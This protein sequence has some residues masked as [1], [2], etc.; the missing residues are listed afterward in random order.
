MTPLRAEE[1][2]A[3]T[4]L[5]EQGDHLVLLH[6]APGTDRHKVPVWYKYQLPRNR[7]SLQQCLDHLEAGGLLGHIPASLG[8]AVVDVDESDPD[9]LFEWMSRYRPLGDV[10]SQRAG[11]LHLYYD[12]RAGWG[13]KNGRRL[14]RYGMRVDVRCM[15]MVA[16]WDLSAVAEI[17]AQRAMAV[18]PGRSLPRTVLGLTERPKPPEWGG[19]PPPERETR[20]PPRRPVMGGSGAYRWR[21]PAPPDELRQTA[22]GGRNT[23][24]FDAV[25]RS[26]YRLPRGSGDDDVRRRWEALWGGFAI[27]ANRMFPEPLGEREVSKTAASVSRW[28]WANPEFGR[29]GDEGRRDPAE[30][31]K[32]G[33]MSGVVRRLRVR[34][35]NAR[36]VELRRREG[37]GL[38]AIA[39]IVEVSASTVWRAV[40]ADKLDPGCFINQSP[41]RQDNS[42]DDGEILG[43]DGNRNNCAAEPS[44]E[45][46]QKQPSRQSETAN[47]VEKR[48][49]T[50]PLPAPRPTS[51]VDNSGGGVD[52]FVS[53]W[54]EALREG[55]RRRADESR[56]RADREWRSWMDRGPPE[57]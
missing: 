43:N 55:V 52:D 11:R 40:E 27:R 41:P 56:R 2:Q 45:N 13:N 26:A 39:R 21:C 4:F 9:G 22:A 1:R 3:V 20:P 6:N 57:E 19:T 30:Q 53:P 17:V 5:H 14:R 25:R 31:S 12:A 33:V 10:P 7:P 44:N 15:G 42:L 8:L 35:R 18:R 37:L 29:G 47:L 28:T 24:L 46:R 34:P 54:E 36:I 16:I 38:R 23:A 48:H 32:R 50:Q 51:S 49:D